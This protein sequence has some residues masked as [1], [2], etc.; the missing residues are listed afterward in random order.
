MTADN[1]RR[2]ASLR[3]I[4]LAAGGLA[5]A[6]GCTKDG[7]E[8]RQAATPGQTATAPA[9]LKEWIEYIEAE[10]AEGGIE[11]FHQARMA[12][13][14]NRRALADE[15]EYDVVSMV[16]RLDETRALEKEAEL[17][18]DLQK[19]AMSIEANPEESAK[20]WLKLRGKLYEER[21][22]NRGIEEDTVVVRI[23]SLYSLIARGDSDI[24]TPEERLGRQPHRGIAGP[25]LHPSTKD[26]FG[27]WLVTG[28]MMGRTHALD[29]EEARE[30]I[31]ATAQFTPKVARF[32]CPMGSERVDK[33]SYV[34]HA[35]TDHRF[36]VEYRE[37]SE[38][39]GLG[40]G[41]TRLVRVL[42]GK[43]DWTWPGGVL[44]MKSRNSLLALWDGVYFE[45]SRR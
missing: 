10:Y 37:D 4:L 12:L 41:P 38:S 23:V 29:T 34:C 32:D 17:A 9:A 44:I 8:G 39:L 45:L 25:R 3:V 5:L 19:L 31:G 16:L 2:V 18:A 35:L 36:Y 27:T 40:K 11:G 21:F 42:D 30:W 13:K 7:G 28:F 1:D 33:P 24:M 15:W 43:N 14:K 26:L 20:H 22:G 6:T